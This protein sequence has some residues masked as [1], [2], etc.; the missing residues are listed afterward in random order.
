MYSYHVRCLGIFFKIPF[1]S[2]PIILL[3][4][5]PI[6]NYYKEVERQY[7]ETLEAIDKINL[8]TII[9]KPNSD[10]GSLKIIKQIDN[11]NFKNNKLVS[12]FQN[13]PELYFTNLMKEISL[14]VGNSSMGILESAIFKTPVVNIG[15]RQIKRQNSGNVIFVSHNKKM[16]IKAIKY[17]LFNLDYQKK[18]KK[19]KNVYGKGNASKKIISILEKIKYKSEILIK[20][21]P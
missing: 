1:T 18:L 21:Y 20:K 16:I 7:K 10:P 19:C 8:P 14:I 17:S 3:V 13:I 11:F 12:I 9:I 15:K 4:Q 2:K 6:S 5:H